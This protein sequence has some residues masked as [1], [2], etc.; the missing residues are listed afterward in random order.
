MGRRIPCGFLINLIVKTDV[1]F[2][3]FECSKPL[4]VIF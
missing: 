4:Q 3:G 1:I 2:L